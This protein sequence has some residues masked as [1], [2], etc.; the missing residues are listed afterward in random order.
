M[1]HTQLFLEWLGVVH[2]ADSAVKKYKQDEWA[3]LC[4][5]VSDVW[6]DWQAQVQGADLFEAIHARCAHPAG[7]LKC[8]NISMANERDI[9]M[10]MMRMSKDETYAAQVLLQAQLHP[11]HYRAPS[12]MRIKHVEKALV[13][14][15]NRLIRHHM[16]M[17]IWREHLSCQLTLLESFLC[18]SEGLK[19]IGMSRVPHVWL[20]YSKLR[21][22]SIECY[23]RPC[24]RHCLS[25]TSK[26]MACRGGCKC[27]Y[28]CAQGSCMRNSKDDVYFGHTEEECA[29]FKD[30]HSIF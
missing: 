15:A 29:L 25:K 7:Y 10:M 23:K 9:L 2:M 6:A 18:C 17:A 19:Q 13:D 8:K 5:A 20:T 14:C 30:T 11:G 4:C 22:V 21:N 28:F 24:C 16:R 12:K 1:E 26:L 3:F 27:V